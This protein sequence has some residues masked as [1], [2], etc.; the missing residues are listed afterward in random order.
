MQ[1]P[2][3]WRIRQQLYLLVGEECHYC[4]ARLF[5]PRTVCPECE[6]P[7][8]APLGRPGNDSLYPTVSESAQYCEDHVY[9]V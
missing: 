4:G 9:S 6:S 3:F 8:R 1:N 2:R 7:A 5:P